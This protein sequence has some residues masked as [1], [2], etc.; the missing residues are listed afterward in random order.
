MGCQRT[1]YREVEIIRPGKLDRFG[2][3]RKYPV[4]DCGWGHEL[5]HYAARVRLPLSKGT[6]KAARPEEAG[7]GKIHRARS[8]LELPRVPR[9]STT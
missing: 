5:S 4:S 8:G 1:M 3:L 9:S 6:V 7:G 2:V